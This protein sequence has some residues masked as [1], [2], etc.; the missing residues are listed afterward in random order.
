[1][2]CP[3]RLTCLQAWASC[4]AVRNVPSWG[5]SHTSGGARSPYGYLTV[6]RPVVDHC[7]RDREKRLGLPRQFVRQTQALAE[8]T[9]RR[10]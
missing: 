5:D 4:A 8:A 2:T 9:S 1:V 10:S 7:G 6:V 3:S